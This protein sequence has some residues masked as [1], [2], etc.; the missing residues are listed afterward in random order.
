MRDLVGLKCSHEGWLSVWVVVI[1]C[2]FFLD[3]CYGANLIQK[4][5][6]VLNCVFY[7]GGSC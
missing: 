5:K 4:C 7:R 3:M 1:N 6:I 2:M